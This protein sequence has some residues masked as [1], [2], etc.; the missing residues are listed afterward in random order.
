MIVRASEVPISA[1]VL[2]AHTSPTRMI[3]PAK[4]TY[5]HMIEML[6]LDSTS[7]CSE[8]GPAQTEG[9]RLGVMAW[10]RIADHS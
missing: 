1:R 4:D 3:S 5:L 10:S 2:I 9:Q 8:S 7:C 6:N